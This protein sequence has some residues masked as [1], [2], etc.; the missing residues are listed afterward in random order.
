MIVTSNKGNDVTSQTAYK[1]IFFSILGALG[2]AMAPV[3][4]W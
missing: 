3:F 2:W 4:G 1:A